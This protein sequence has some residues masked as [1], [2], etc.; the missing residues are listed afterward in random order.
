MI[1]RVNYFLVV[2]DM[3]ITSVR[4]RFD[5]MVNFK[6]VFGFLFD[7]KKIKVLGKS[8]IREHCTNI[9]KVFFSW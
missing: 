7:L 8:E 9:H 2:V 5:E 4:N 6:N 1:F 3:A